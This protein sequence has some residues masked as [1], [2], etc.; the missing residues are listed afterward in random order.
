MYK[1]GIKYISPE[2]QMSDLVLDNPYVA[3]MLEHFDIRFPL[4]EQSI[5]QLCAEHQIN[6]KLFLTLT[7]LYCG[8]EA[9]L[10]NRYSFN[11]IL[12]LVNYLKKSHQ[13]Y[14]DEIYPLI[15]DIIR[16]MSTAND[17]EEMSLVEKFFNE[18]FDEV[19]EH[20]HYENN[21]V[22]PY[23]LGL[24]EKIVHSELPFN[25]VKYSVIEYKEHHNDIEEKLADLKN[26]LIKYLP[27]KNDQ[28]LR[29]K[30]LLKLYEL[31]FDLHIHSQIEDFILIPLVSQMET[32]LKKSE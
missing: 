1:H 17:R 14:T 26:L 8:L 5:A 22:F 27:Q 12:T 25:P 9:K 15:L 13:Y 24:Y 3:L 6:E 20:L 18:Y 28:F 10:E 30:L 16:Q 11:D 7:R 29:R 23:V 21:T 4:N 31:E 32:H 2:D 19:T